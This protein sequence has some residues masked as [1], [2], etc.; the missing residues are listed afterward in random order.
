MATAYDTANIIIPQGGGYKSGSLYGWNPQDSSLVD[1]SVARAGA[2]ATR[3]NSSG[4]IE[5]VSAN[6]PRWDWAEGGSCPSLLIEPQRSN[7]LTYSEDFSTNWTLTN[8]TLSSSG[9]NP[10]GETGVLFEGSGSSTAVRIQ[11]GVTV[12]AADYNLSFFAKQGT[13][14]YIAILLSGIDGSETAYYDLQSG[15]VTSDTSG[16]A[17]MVNYGDGWYKCILPATPTGPDF[18][19]DANIFLSPDGLTTIY[20]S[21]AATSG[22]NVEIYGGQLEAGSYATSY[23]PTTSSTETRNADVISKTS[24][25]SLLGDSAGTLFVEAS[26]FEANGSGWITVNNNGA[27]NRV[28]IFPDAGTN[29]V[30]FGNSESGSTSGSVQNA[31]YT[32]STDGTFYKIAGRYALNDM[33]A[34]VDG[35]LIGT[36]TSV[37]VYTDGTLTDIDFNAGVNNLPFYGRIRQFVVFDQALTDSELAAITS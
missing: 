28:F 31:S 25:A 32:I 5:S 35:N 1:F 26:W 24:I 33:A 8:A 13:E 19:G 18:N 34:Y 4:L 10:K 17:S 30:R 29:Q 9:T 6:V 15:V 3:V 27:T 23:I 7:L 11:Q 16:G 21:S 36:D 20:G 37:N 22:Q 14:R 2:T 12:T